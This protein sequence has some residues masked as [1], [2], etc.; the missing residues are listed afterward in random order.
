MKTFKFELQLFAGDTG[1]DTAGATGD[2]NSAADS[3]STGTILGAEN[4]T[5]TGG[6]SSTENSTDTD[7][8]SG[9]P[10]AYDFTGIVPDGME[11]DEASAKKFGKLARAANLSQEQANTIAS[12][13]MKYMQ[14]GVDAAMQKIVETQAEWGN[15]ARKEL[16][17]QFDS[18]VSKAAAGIN[19]LS[20]KIPNIR[21]TLNETGA[22]NRI[23]FIRMF[24]AI[25]DLLGEDK[26]MN[27][28]MGGSNN[29]IYENTDFSKYK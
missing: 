20:A 9:A 16:G 2:E 17:A 7:D 14:G 6:K 21:Q 26:G 1:E 8:S 19:A 24:A 5:P 28:G 29:T 3:S 18:T 4:G 27:S 25:G 22:G 15:A 23:E 10:A 11:Y 12:Y 13:G